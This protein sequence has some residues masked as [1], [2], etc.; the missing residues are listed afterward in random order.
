MI[1]GLCSFFGDLVVDVPGVRMFG[2]DA[3]VGLVLDAL[4]VLSPC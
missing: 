2:F 4:R 1:S 3:L